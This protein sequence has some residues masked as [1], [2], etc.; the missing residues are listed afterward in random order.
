MQLSLSY[1]LMHLFWQWWYFLIVSPLD[2]SLPLSP[3]LI[4]CYAFAAIRFCYLCLDNVFQ[5]VPF[6]SSVPAPAP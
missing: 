1:P 5:Q 2:F 3:P 6:S 4:F